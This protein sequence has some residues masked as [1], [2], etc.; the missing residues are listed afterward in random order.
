MSLKKPRDAKT[1]KEIDVCAVY[2]VKIDLFI[3][4]NQIWGAI[5]KIGQIIK[6]QTFS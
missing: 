2:T 1:C 6:L 4:V 5:R 3:S